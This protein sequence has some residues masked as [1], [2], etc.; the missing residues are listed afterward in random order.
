[1]EQPLKCYSQELQL[2]SFKC[3]TSKNVPSSFVVLVAYVDDILLFSDENNSNAAVAMCFENYFEIRE[4]KIAD[5]FL[6]VFVEE[7]VN[8][9][10]LYNAPVI[11]KLV[12]RFEME[13]AKPAKKSLPSGFDLIWD[14]SKALYDNAPFSLLVAAWLHLANTVRADIAYAVG[15]LSLF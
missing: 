11:S 12:I 10:C 15:Y 2:H 6:S 8:Q 5:K 14:G 13:N 7:F 4:T 3:C 9:V 1:M